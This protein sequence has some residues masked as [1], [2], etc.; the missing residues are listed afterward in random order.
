MTLSA[1]LLALLA[2]FFA[3]EVAGNFRD[4]PED[5]FGYRSPDAAPVPHKRPTKKDVL[6][7]WTEYH[8]FT[9]PLMGHLY[10]ECEGGDSPWFQRVRRKVPPQLTLLD[11]ED[12]TD[13]ERMV[14]LGQ[15]HIEDFREH[16]EHGELPPN[17]HRFL[18]LEAESRRRIARNFRK[19]EAFAK[20]HEVKIPD[21]GQKANLHDHGHW[22]EGSHHDATPEGIARRRAA[23]RAHRSQQ[24]ELVRDAP[25]H[26]DVGRRTKRQRHVTGEEV[27]QRHLEQHRLNWEEEDA[28]D[29]RRNIAQDENG[30]DVPVPAEMARKRRKLVVSTRP[31]KSYFGDTSADER[32]E[33]RRSWQ[34]MSDDERVE[35][36][37][38]HDPSRCYA[39][40]SKFCDGLVHRFSSFMTCVV[41][42][43]HLFEAHDS[44]CL[45]DFV[46]LHKPCVADMVSYCSDMPSR[47]TLLCL[48]KRSSQ[49]V[50]PP[51][52]TR[53]TPS[54]LVVP[55]DEAEPDAML[56]PLSAECDASELLHA[57]RVSEVH[58]HETGHGAVG[59]DPNVKPLSRKHLE[60]IHAHQERFISQQGPEGVA[61][62]ELEGHSPQHTEEEEELAYEYDDPIE[63]PASTG[64]PL[65]QPPSPVE[66]EEADF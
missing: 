5:M 55:E 54:G 58:T 52:G 50:R 62:H 66:G 15:F 32:E 41:A 47:D 60:R 44:H 3:A 29:G 35:Y 21:H 59:S 7:D 17:I 27:A 39:A 34:S 36:G 57:A 13:E 10:K 33:H 22:H 8:L 24:K 65:D 56:R 46:T 6:P 43:S 63:P 28:K 61:L 45:D 49:P 14:Y 38:S 1:S 51:V 37:H 42:K 20:K 9:R 30:E 2:V 26:P 25:T 64:P 16:G 31:K 23:E 18:R 12:M 53:I 11:M 4:M 19:A 48:L 40:A